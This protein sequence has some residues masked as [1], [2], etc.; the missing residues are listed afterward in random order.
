MAEVASL[1]AMFESREPHSY[2]SCP[3]TRPRT[4]RLLRSSKNI[5]PPYNIL[6]HVG[7]A[8][9]VT[10]QGINKGISKHKRGWK[11]LLFFGR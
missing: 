1:A 6:S 11:K 9:D 2:A 10:F 7:T 4:V 5:C 3:P 8:E